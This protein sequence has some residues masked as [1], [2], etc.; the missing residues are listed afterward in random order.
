[1]QFV[2]F[3]Y[4]REDKKIAHKTCLYGNCCLFAGGKEIF[5]LFYYVSEVDCLKS[6]PKHSRSP[7]AFLHA[8]RG[9]KTIKSQ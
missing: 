7:F 4:R 5:T 1:M 6:V 2:D 3:T 9:E 8:T